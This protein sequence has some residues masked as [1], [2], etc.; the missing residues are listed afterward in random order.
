VIVVTFKFWEK[1]LVLVFEFR[2]RFGNNTEPFIKFEEDDE[3]LL[4]EF[5]Y[6][7]LLIDAIEDGC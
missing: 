3:I 7:T 6:N 2:I 4:L 1:G 5:D